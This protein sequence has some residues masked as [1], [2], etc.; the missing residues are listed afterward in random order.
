MQFIP[1]TWRAY[2]V[3]AA[4]NRAPDPFNINDAAL[5]AAHYLCVAGGDLRT[6]AGE[7]RAVMAYNHS[8]SYVNEVLGLAHAYAAGIPV[9]DIPLVGN[10]SDPVPALSGYYGTTYSNAPASP[11]PAIGASDNTPA[12]GPTTG[13]S[14]RPA[15]S[16]GSSRGAAGAPSGSGTSAGQ[17]A[18]DAGSGTSTSGSG[19]GTPTGT[20]PGSDPGSGPAP[21]GAPAPA[22]A[23]IPVPV[24]VPVPTLPAAPGQKPPVLSIPK[25][26]GVP[27]PKL[28][29]NPLCV[30][31]LP[32]PC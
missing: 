22:P 18:S 5:A 29:A 3:S 10:T 15:A 20:A 25:V 16:K 21:A 4:S 30:R 32:T 8:D 7:R 11:G 1:S 19:P 27:A 26:P 23:P 31:T 28:P 17:P 12:S 2:A 14:S 9:A 13:A 6:S 24:P